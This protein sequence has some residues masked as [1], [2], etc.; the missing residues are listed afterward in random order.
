MCPPKVTLAHTLGSTPAIPR[1][2]PAYAT[3][4]SCSE[5]PRTPPPFLWLLHLL[6]HLDLFLL[7]FL[8][9]LFH[10]PLLFLIFLLLPILFIL[11]L[12]LL[13]PLL[14]N[15]FYLLLLVFLLYTKNVL[16]I[17]TIHCLFYLFFLHST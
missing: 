13:L 11:L 17:I 3:S 12:V 14:F 7:L 4:Y 5:F 8:L 9:L 16:F 15:S 10:L 1:P 2:S 6:F